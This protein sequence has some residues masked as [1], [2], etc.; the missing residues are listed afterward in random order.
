MAKKESPYLKI[1]MNCLRQEML[2]LL[3]L[4]MKNVNL[5]LIAVDTASIQHFIMAGFL[6][7]LLSG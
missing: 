4:S 6:M 7:S 3:K 1:L 5:L 2:K